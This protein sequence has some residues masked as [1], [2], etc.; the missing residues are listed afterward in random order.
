[1]RQKVL[2][3]LVARR[4]KQY[5]R[6]QGRGISPKK[7]QR[8]VAEVQSL[9]SF[10][11]EQAAVK[12]AALQLFYHA[13]LFIQNYLFL[14]PEERLARAPQRSPTKDVLSDFQHFRV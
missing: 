13:Q 14:I 1:M 4:V 8:S 10:A 12:E 3:R 2:A 6:G 7:I 5:T 9:C 11:L